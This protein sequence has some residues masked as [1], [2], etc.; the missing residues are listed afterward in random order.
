E[1]VSEGEIGKWYVKEGDFVKKDQPILEILTDKVNMEVP[2][3]YEG[4]VTKI[5]HHEGDVVKVGT[6]ILLMDANQG[7]SAPSPSATVVSTPA[8]KPAES[9]V[10]SAAKAPALTPAPKSSVPSPEHFVAQA[11][12]APAIRALAKELKVDLAAVRGSGPGGRITKEDVEAEVKGGAA[13]ASAPS[14]RPVAAPAGPEERIPYRGKRR[15]IALHLTES[16][17][18]AVHTLYV[19]EVDVTNLVNLRERL[20]TTAEAKGIKLTYLPFLIKGLA[21]ALKAYPWMNSTLDMEK[22]EVVLK[23]YYNIGMAVDTDDGLVVPVIKGVDAKSVFEIAR[24]MVVL[25]D[26]ARK[27]TLALE[28]VQGSTFTVTSAGHIGGFLSM[29]IISYPEVA[30]LGVHRIKKRPAVV[31]NQIM[32]RDMVN[33]SISFDHRVVDGATVARF[34]NEYMKFVQSPELLLPEKP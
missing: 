12:A 24:E 27:G 7:A 18:T 6:P 28:E 29:P 14:P 21:P 2:S 17:N 1:S 11:V 13:T 32:A 22:G 31:D 10:P 26:T 25:A 19:E 33:L 5:L 9:T 3:P 8:A 30:I 4:Y 20:A 23:K 34:M 16:Y 15:M